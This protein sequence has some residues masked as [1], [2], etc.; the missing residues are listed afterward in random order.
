[1]RLFAILPAIIGLST[2]A[3]SGQ[4]VS[5]ADIAQG[6]HVHGLAV[7]RTDPA[8]LLIA[9]HHG[10]FRAGSDGRAELIS[11]VQDF[12]GFTPHPTDATRLFA[13]GHPA[14]GG[15]LGFIASE[16]R[17]ATWRQLSEGVDG[18]VDFHQLTISAANPDVLYGAHAGGLQ[19]SR[20]GGRN[21]EAIAE[22]PPELIDLAASR[23]EA[24]TLYAATGQGLLASRDAGRTWETLLGGA[25]VAFVE[26]TGDGFLYAFSLERGLVRR[27]ET[28]P[29]DFETVDPNVGPILI[30]F[31]A[32][33]TAPQKLYAA[34]QDGRILASRDRGQ[35]WDAF[36]GR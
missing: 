10:L 23:S 27:T 17:G 19:V 3:A 30:H 35:S 12:M 11:P 25:P 18:P 32:D 33:P 28:G 14:E 7:D 22:A 1:M 34:S 6:T 36:G 21:W 15:N 2:L 26:V 8:F 20:D 16:D 13:S 29:G 5:L 4:E 24:A 9:T 31:A